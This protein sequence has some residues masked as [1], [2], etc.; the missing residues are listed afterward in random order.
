ME[1]D[2]DKPVREPGHA[3]DFAKVALI[4]FLAVLAVILVAR[5]VVG[6]KLNL[7]GL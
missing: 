4:V 1:Q 3:P 7:L 5:F 2:T 6:V